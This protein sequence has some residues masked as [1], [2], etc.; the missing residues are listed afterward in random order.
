MILNNEKTFG[1]KHS[2]SDLST[3]L[4]VTERTEGT[5]KKTSGRVM[6]SQLRFKPGTTR[7]QVRIVTA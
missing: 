1:R 5:H 4:A 6:M 3:T 7:I 2:R